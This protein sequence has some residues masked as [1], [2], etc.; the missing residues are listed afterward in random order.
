MTTKY[1]TTGIVLGKRD[2]AESDRI[3]NIFSNEF[4]AVEL[5]AK[6]IRKINS[7][8]KSGIDLFYLSEIE[9]IEGKHHKTLTDAFAIKRFDNIVRDPK[10]IKTAGRISEILENFLKGQR[11]DEEAFYLLQE[12]FERI[13]FHDFKFKNYELIYYYFL[14]NFLASQGYRPE[15]ANCVLCKEKLNPYSVYFSC[16]EGG[17][18]CKK[19]LDSDRGA[20]KINSDVVKVLRIILDKDWQTVSKLKIEESSRALFK[21]ISDYAVQNFCPA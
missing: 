19:C 21:K 17:V 3:F 13:D 5:H 15:V 4:G 9:F 12:T 6:A 1:R 7:K 18:I 10:K 2:K 14:W 16:R 8:L 20:Q 11:K